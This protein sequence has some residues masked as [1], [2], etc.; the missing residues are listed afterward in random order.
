MNV[1]IRRIITTVFMVIA[2]S[3][4]VYAVDATAEIPK[5]SVNVNG[6]EIHTAQSQYPVLSY[7]GVTYL[8]MT[9]DV[10]NAMGLSVAWGN[11]TGLT[12][13]KNGV[14][15][16][17]KESFLGARNKLGTKVKV[18]ISAFPI[19][20][21]GKKIDNGSEK[22][23][24]L[25]YK[26][27]TYFP[28]TW[29]F[30]VSEFG[31]KTVWDDKKGLTIVTQS[32]GEAISVLG[33]PGSTAAK[34]TLKKQGET[35]EGELKDGIPNG[36][37]TCTYFNGVEYPNSKGDVYI[38]QWK[39][40][41]KQGKGKMLYGRLPLQ[42]YVYEGDW[43]NDKED[44]Y[45][46]QVSGS[47]QNA[48]YEGQWKNGDFDGIGTYT[49][50]GYT[51]TGGYKD[52]RQRGQGTFVGAD[53][54]KYEG[55]INSDGKLEGAVYY[56]FA[57]G[58]EYTGQFVDGQFEGQ[59]KYIS[60]DGSEYEG[61]WLSGKRN[62]HGIMKHA[63]GFIYDGEWFKGQQSGMCTVIYA[64]GSKYE[65]NYL[66]N[67]REGQGK[68]TFPGGYVQEGMWSRDFLITTM[69]YQ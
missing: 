11:D 5:Y 58:D 67:Q 3:V 46:V 7:N 12:I 2:A 20:I 63:S 40:G 44:G 21:N 45:G 38:G 64:D 52:G 23:P 54:S 48:K 1:N 4:A 59:G 17:L 42:G 18:S 65:G 49:C 10:A 68:L 24:I 50:P 55:M 31:W 27:V 62:G 9:S 32:N 37:G 66:N 61:G 33:T 34:G 57:N 47:T 15:G 25:T 13:E 69:G 39:D 28:M 36:Y 43:S 41:K 19:V 8:P 6:I 26:S 29:R 53:G 16:Q 51:Y 30:A 35:Y 60:A 14:Y 22:F 56:R